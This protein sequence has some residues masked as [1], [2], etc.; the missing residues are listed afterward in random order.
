MFTNQAHF[1]LAAGVR[2]AADTMN[3]NWTAGR[4]RYEPATSGALQFKTHYAAAL[5]KLSQQK[6]I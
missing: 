3:K 4:S 1:F 5:I 2:A 6:I